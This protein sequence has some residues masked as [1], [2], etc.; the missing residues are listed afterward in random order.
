MKKYLILLLGVASCNLVT[1]DKNNSGVSDNI[2]ITKLTSNDS[3][4]VRGY[5]EKSFSTPLHSLEHQQYLDSALAI[6]PDN[7]WLWQQ[8]AMPLY[9]ARKYQLGKPFLAKAVAHDP[10]KWLDYSGFMKCIFSKDYLNSI[11][12]LI[13]AK[14]EYGDSYVMDH[15]YNFYIGLDYLQLNEFNKAKEF[16]VKSKEQQFKD[17]P[18]ALPQEACHYLDWYYSGIADFELGNYQEAIVSFDMALKGYDNFADALYFKGRSMTKLGNV[19]EGVEWEK[20]AFENG[21]NSF[22]EDNAIYEIYPYQVFHKLNES[23]RPK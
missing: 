4:R 2:E 19:E 12:D 8:K 5:I 20:K 13:K 18:N 6:Q 14:N 7:A 3:V 16:L 15:T 23:V 17:F 21:D 22:N 10:K 1:K 11:T 9:K